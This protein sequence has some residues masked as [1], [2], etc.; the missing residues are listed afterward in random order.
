MQRSFVGNEDYPPNF[1]GYQN[2]IYYNQ[3]PDFTGMGTGSF[4]GGSDPL[5][6]TSIFGLG[7]RNS[8]TKD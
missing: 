3:N 2:N 6:S 5:R 4:G 8:R 1:G 7:H